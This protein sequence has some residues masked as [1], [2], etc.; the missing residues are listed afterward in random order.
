LQERRAHTHTHTHTHIREKRMAAPTET[1]ESKTKELAPETAEAV[2]KQCE[3]YFGDANLP[4]DAFL[5]G[6]VDSNEGGWV[7]IAL[8]ATFKR[9]RQILGMTTTTTTT[10]KGAAVEPVSEATVAAIAAALRPSSLLEVSEDGKRVHRRVPYAVIPGAEKRTVYVKGW[11]RAK[12][13][14]LEDVAKF[15]E[16]YG[17]VL[18]VRLRRSTVGKYR[19]KFKGTLTVEFSSEAEAQALLAAK[20]TPPDADPDFTTIYQPYTEWFEE[21]KQEEAEREKR[22]KEE[23]GDA[24]ERKTKRQKKETESVEIT[25]ITEAPPAAAAAATAAGERKYTPGLVVKV[26]G[27]PKDA[28]TRQIKFVLFKS[29]E[30]LFVGTTDEK[31]TVLARCKDPRN[32]QKLV[33]DAAEDKLVGVAKG[34]KI[35]VVEG[36]E[37]K[38]FWEEAWQAISN[39][40]AGGRGRGRRRERGKGHRPHRGRGGKRGSTGVREEEEEEGKKEAKKMKKEDGDEKKPDAASTAPESVAA[41]AP[42]PAPAPEATPVPESAPIVADSTTTT[43]AAAAPTAPLHPLA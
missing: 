8:I 7:D 40:E 26:S 38:K 6:K 33:Q 5:K 17:K 22:R 42:A 23:G 21:K 18:A 11:P 24:E 9:M 2:L 30:V 16:A 12:E 32:A 10:P 28:D 25:E 37:E 27:L 1:S 29:A 3:F 20:P 31:G 39:A 43:A 4:T 14:K 36:D 34:A 41:P 19:G 35:A 15:Y 13:P